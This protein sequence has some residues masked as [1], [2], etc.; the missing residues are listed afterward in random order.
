MSFKNFLNDH[1]VIERDGGPVTYEVSF[2]GKKVIGPLDMDVEED[3]L[4]IRKSTDERFIV[5]SV[6]RHKAPAIM[7]H[8][9]SH[10]TLT[11]VYEKQALKRRE[12]AARTQIIQH[13]GSAHTVAGRD[14]H[15]G[16][17]TTI[18]VTN[19]LDALAAAVTE[20]TS[21]PEDQK[22]SLIGQIRALSTN[23]FIL[24]IAPPLILEAL[25]KQFGL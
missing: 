7:R 4:L 6:E 22:P 21:I 1:I 17:N 10:C 12:E 9:M 2:Q 24:G 5:T 18:T 20:D 11:L 14:I 3:D 8:D 23:P 16:V 15:G 19:I 25:K 13:I